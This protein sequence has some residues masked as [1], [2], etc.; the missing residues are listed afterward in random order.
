MSPG[1]EPLCPRLAATASSLVLAG[2]SLV[3]PD[4]AAQPT[5]P[6]PISV[7]ALPRRAAHTA[8][9][10]PD[11]SVLVAGGCD[12]DGCG[13]AT[14]TTFLLTTAGAHPGPPL[15]RPRDGHTA[16]Q[17]SDGRVLVVGGYAGEG[18]PPLGSAEIFDPSSG[19]WSAT[20]PLDLGRGGHAS[21]RLGDNRVVVTGGWAAPRTPTA[22]TEIFD[23]HSGAFARGPDLPEAVDGHAASMLPDGTVLVVGGLTGRGRPR[24][25]PR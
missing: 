17:L 13:R 10:L 14:A 2:C 3:P 18:E 6:V 7:A 4:T 8:T 23:P 15:E 22:R 19:R 9:P 16:T 1:C 11:G 25:R 24:R 20:E 21:T 5:T 12:I